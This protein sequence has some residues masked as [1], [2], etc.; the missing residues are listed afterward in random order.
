MWTIKAMG[1]TVTVNGGGTNI[2]NAATDTLAAWGVGRYVS[3]GTQWM[4]V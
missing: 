3:N 2:D 1:F 4:K